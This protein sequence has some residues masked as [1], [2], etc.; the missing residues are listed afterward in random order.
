MDQVYIAAAVVVVAAVAAWFVIARNKG[1]RA[2]P[3]GRIAP[4]RRYN[5]LVALCRQDV[6]LPER[7]IKF[8][9]DRDA[10]IPRDEAIA[11]AIR[12]LER[13]R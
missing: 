8:E 11:R 1:G 10:T 3:V 4:D 5:E 9:I 12:R 13:D 7:L 6:S 2:A